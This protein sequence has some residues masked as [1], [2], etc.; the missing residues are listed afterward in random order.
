MSDQ[1]IFAAL[2]T[3]NAGAACGLQSRKLGAA[4]AVAVLQPDGVQP[5]FGRR[6]IPLDVNAHWLS[7]IAIRVNWR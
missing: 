1:R 3:R 6:R 7:A 4:E 5:E 2:R